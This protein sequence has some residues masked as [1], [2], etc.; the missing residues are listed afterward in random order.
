[1]QFVGCSSAV[2]DAVQF[3]GCCVIVQF[4]GC[5]AVCRMYCTISSVAVASPALLAAGVASFPG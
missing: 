3:V 2:C 5:S 1:M 4:V